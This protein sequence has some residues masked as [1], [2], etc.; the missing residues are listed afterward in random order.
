MTKHGH[1]LLP[2]HDPHQM[3]V[4]NNPQLGQNHAVI[5]Y[6]LQKIGS[7]T[8]E[9]KRK[10]HYGKDKAVLFVSILDIH[11]MCKSLDLNVQIMVRAILRYYLELFPVQTS[12][13]IPNNDNKSAF[14]FPVSHLFEFA[15]GSGEMVCGIMLKLVLLII[16]S[17]A[18]KQYG[19]ENSCSSMHECLSYSMI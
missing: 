1:E 16:K 8:N 5:Y 19:I 15:L 9:E 12:I 3:A 10:E 4:L 2:F 7:T 13:P 11:Q 14:P 18:Q 17:G 6:L